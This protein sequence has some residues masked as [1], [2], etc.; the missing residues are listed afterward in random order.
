MDA[1]KLQG[2]E[3]KV[4][5]VGSDEPRSV[6]RDQPF[7]GVAGVEDGFGDERGELLAAFLFHHEGVDDVLGRMV[8]ADK[9]A[10]FLTSHPD[11]L[12]IHLEE[13]APGRGEF[14]RHLQGGLRSPADLI[15][16][17]VERGARHRPTE[18]LFQEC[19]EDPVGGQPLDVEP[20][21]VE[22]HVVGEAGSRPARLAAGGEAGLAGPTEEPLEGLE[23]PLE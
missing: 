7:Q 13:P 20:D 2:H 10:G 17:G 21:R 19:G 16:P 5:V 22:D 12:P 9:K 11:R 14:G 3:G 1:T 18:S 4:V 6:V 23:A 8:H 15:D